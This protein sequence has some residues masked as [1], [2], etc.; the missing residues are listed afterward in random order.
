MEKKN[1]EI[2][3]YVGIFALILILMGGNN[4]V[5]PGGIVSI[6]GNWDISEQVLEQNLE[7]Y[8]IEEEDFDYSDPQ[9]YKLAQDIKSSTA[10]PYDAVKATARYVYDN[11]QYS[12]KVSVNF[13]Y[14]ETAS[15][16]LEAGT[17]DCV[18]M[19]RLATALLRAQGIPTRTM[20][21]CLASSG[22]CSPLFAVAP[23]EITAQ[24][25]TMVEDDFKKRGFLHEW[26]EFWVP[27]GSEDGIWRIGEATSGQIFP[28]GCPAYIQFAYDN[29]RFNRCV[30]QDN[31]F[32]NLCSI[33]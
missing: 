4:D 15:S 21:G 27:D 6:E 20:G 32:W 7:Q 25:T 24:V 8:T 30:I 19:V 5:K 3:L 10:T 33:S 23:P 28:I 9:V 1:E 22:R 17:G 31:N 14:E 12:S 11:I 29:N 16:A 26:Y 18:S 2:L 13:C